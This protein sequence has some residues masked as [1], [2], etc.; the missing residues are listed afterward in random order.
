VLDVARA[1][2]NRAEDLARW[3]MARLVNRRD[4]WG[5][6]YRTQDAAGAWT[7][8]QMTC[9]K[10]ADRGRVLLTRA[11]LERHFRAVCTRDVKGLHTTSPENT[12]LWGAVDIDWH[13]PESTAPGVNLRAALAWYDRLRERGWHPLLTSSNGQGGYHLRLLLAQPVETARLH[14]FMQLLV[15]DY[16]RHGMTAAPETFPR[17]AQLG[18]GRR[19]GNWLRLPG[20]HHTRDYWSC[21]WDGSCWLAGAAAVEHILSLQGDPVEVVPPLP[22][23]PPPPKRRP[24]VLRAPGGSL[25]ARVAGYMRKL[26]NLGEGQCR[27]D[28]GYHFAC[29]LVRDM[30][31]SEDVARQWLALWDRDNRPPKGAECI[32]KWIRNARRYGQHA[33][34][35]GREPASAGGMQVIRT[36]RPGHVILRSSVEVE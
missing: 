13:G 17:Q 10:I 9:P 14:A 31:L 30:A 6:Y 36:H 22:A 35:C 27:D 21:V 12:S 2:A 3:T 29:W 25:S 34:G 16:R 5:G 8:C 15:R 28:V 4:A 20:R 23:Q 18:D 11:I 26:P 7:T 33:E 24:F 1:W 19:Y 32:E